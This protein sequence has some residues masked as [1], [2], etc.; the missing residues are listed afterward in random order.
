MPGRNQSIAMLEPLLEVLSTQRIILASG[1]PRRSEILQKIGLKFDV[2]PSLF[3]ENLDKSVFNHPSDYVLENSKQKTLEVARRIDAKDGKKHLIIGADTVVV[4]NEKILEKPSDKD[5]AFEMLKSLSGKDHQVFSGVT[6]VQGNLSKAIEDSNMIQ[7]YEET[8]VSFGDL[9]DDVIH[10]YIETGEPMD[11]AG[12][13]G[14]QGIGG[15]LVKSIQGDYFNVMGFPLHH[16][17]LQI[18]K[19]FA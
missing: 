5:H 2:I 16:F 9:T 19:L 7:F 14:I 8:L 17:C 3:E 4:L 18:R 15:T 10:G 6:L 1:S 12:S 11:K 13:Y